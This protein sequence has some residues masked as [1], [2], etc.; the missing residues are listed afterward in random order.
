[1][2]GTDNQLE[3]T[4]ITVKLFGVLRD[5]TRTNR[6]QVEGEKTILRILEH[7]AELYGPEVRNLLLEK[8]TGR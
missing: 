2:A 5:R 6:V 1:L 4:T 8:K 3:V 7:L